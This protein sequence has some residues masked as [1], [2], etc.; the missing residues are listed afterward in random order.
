MMTVVLGEHSINTKEEF[1][2]IFSVSVIIRHYNYKPWSFN[3]DIMLIK[4]WKENELCCRTVWTHIL[5]LCNWYLNHFTIIHPS[6]HYPTRLIPSGVAGVCWSLSP[7][8]LGRRQGSTLDRSPVRRRA[9]FTIS[10]TL[11][12]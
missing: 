6:I 1:E 10:L 5:K 11:K 3:N 9:H 2:Q 4:V 8:I 12:N 7:A